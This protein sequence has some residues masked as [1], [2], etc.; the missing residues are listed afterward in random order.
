MSKN[1]IINNSFL[2]DGID[3]INN[4]VSDIELKNLKEECELLFSKKSLNGSLGS[5]NISKSTSY[6][7]MPVISVRSINLLEL[8]LRIK[9]KI[10]KF[11]EN[12][13]TY[14]NTNIEIMKKTKSDVLPWHTDNRK[15]MI[16]AIIYIYIDEN[17]SGLFRYMKKTHIR[18]FVVEH[19]LNQEQ[20][21]KFS[22]DLVTCDSPE[23]S[24]ILFNSYGFH[25]R[26]KV[27]G[28][29]IS[30]T[31]DFLPKNSDYPKTAIPFSSRNLT[32]DVIK[33]LSFFLNNA[34]KRYNHGGELY[35]RNPPKFISPIKSLLSKIFR[36]FIKKK[37]TD[38]KNI[39]GQL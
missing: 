10:Q 18:D 1:S 5:I 32:D 11:D 26:E 33:D 24:L 27:E 2:Q 6:L 31:F 7:M 23:G 4:F 29:R 19:H 37:N 17:K 35:Y 8:S 22:K 13:K 3:V 21:L 36:K 39:K 28:K 20:I 30:I 34:D 38:K 25:G 12:F 14:E 9:E 15:G 16:R